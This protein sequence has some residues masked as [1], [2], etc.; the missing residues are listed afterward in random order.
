MTRIVAGVAGGRTLKVP[1]S[2]TRPTS[3]RV[4]EALFSRLE[5]LDVV[6]GARVLDLYAG[7]GALGL[8]AASRGA[9]RVTLVEAARAAAALCRANAEAL[10]LDPLIDVVA[11]RVQTH[12][13]GAGTPA[14]LV[15]LDPPYDVEQEDLA[16]VL[17]LLGRG[18]LAPDAVVV[19]ERDR[20]SP[21]PR[22]PDHLAALGPRS[23][24][25]TVVWF[26]E[27]AGSGG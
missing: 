26:A 24:G 7:S 22:W 2:G 25:D 8:E 12:L 4:R 11:A 17:A 23:Y 19:V 13:A 16:D 18:W 15:L 10:G 1:R 3:E 21:E 9:A 5:H 14:D 6:D 20:R 27:A